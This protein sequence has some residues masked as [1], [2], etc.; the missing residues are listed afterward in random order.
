MP[1]SGLALGVVPGRLLGPE[2]GGMA[3]VVGT[4]GAL[5]VLVAVA[6]PALKSVPLM[7]ITLRSFTRGRRAWPTR[8]GSCNV[9][10]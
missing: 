6:A 1:S 3:L 2:A 10:S 8:A 9:I 7:T 5:L 4:I